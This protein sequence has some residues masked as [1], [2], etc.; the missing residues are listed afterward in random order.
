MHIKNIEIGTAD[1]P[2]PLDHFFFCFL[3]PVAAGAWFKGRMLVSENT[4][5]AVMGLSGSPFWLSYG[6]TMRLSRVYRQSCPY[7]LSYNNS[8]AKFEWGMTNH[9]RALNPKIC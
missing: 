2:F 4:G 7:L 1:A 5:L 3:P 8:D 9:L 6:G